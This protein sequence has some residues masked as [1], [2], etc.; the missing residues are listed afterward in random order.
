MTQLPEYMLAAPTVFAV[1]HQYHI[2]MPFT[3][4][5][6]LRVEVG[7]RIY[8]DHCNG[9]LRSNTLMHKVELPMSVLDEAGEYTVVYKK[10][11][12]RQPYFPRSEDERRWTVS[13]RPVKDSGDI[14]VYH[15]SDT[16]NLV[17]EP[18]AAGRYFGDAIDL[19]VLNGDIPNHSGD[20]ENFNAIYKIAAGITGGHCPCVFARGNHDTRG[21]HAED[22]PHYIPTVNGRTY[23]TFRVGCVW[24]LLLDCGEDKCDEHPEY[25]GTICFHRFR[26]EET[27]FIRDV[28]ANADREY[29]APG[30]KHRL[31]ISHVAFTHILRPPFDIERELYDEWARLMRTYIRPDLLLYG[32]HHVVDICPVGSDFDHR[33]QACTAIIGSKPIFARENGGTD[34]FIGTGIVLGE[35]GKKRIV[36]NDDKGTVLRDEIID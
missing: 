2:F 25:G 27:D 7:D 20:I 15:I 13:F 9:I 3:T 17:D 12:D 4:D 30:V 36:F 34:G 28:I 31:V 22:M 33:G 14:R 24:G 35:N 11:I 1:G 21:I 19:L 32:H 18:M 5:V 26:E 6:I 23:Y 16:H 8:Y 29:A 10:M